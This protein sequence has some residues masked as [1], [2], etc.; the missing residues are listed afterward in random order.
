VGS[1]PTV[2]TMDGLLQASREFAECSRSSP[3][4]TEP[5]EMSPAAL[6]RLSAAT[7][8]LLAAVELPVARWTR[9][10]A[11]A[12]SVSARGRMQLVVGDA[13]VVHGGPG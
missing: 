13:L 9:Q 11:S 12:A 5:P 8:A 4:S 7:A 2:R 6:F 10:L 3:S 1:S